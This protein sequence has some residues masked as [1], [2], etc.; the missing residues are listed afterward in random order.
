MCLF[1]IRAQRQETGR[2]LLDKEG[3]LVL[4]CGQCYECKSKRA[5]EWS[6]RATHE[7]SQYFDNC[8][9]T[10]TYDD[11]HLSSQFIVKS[12]FQKFMKRLRKKTQANIRYMVS[13]EYGS[14]TGRPHHHAIIFGWSPPAQRFI[15]TTAKGSKLYESDYI[16]DLWKFGFHSIGE[17]NEQTAYYIASYS[18]KST[19]HNIINNDTGEYCEVRDS[20]NVSTRPAIG[21]EFFLS[22][23]ENIVKTSKILPRYYKKLLETYNP[24]LLEWYENNSSLEFKTRSSHELLAKFKITEQK[25][26]SSDDGLRTAPEEKLKNDILTKQLIRDRDYYVHAT[27]K[28]GKQC[29]F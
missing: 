9:I 20:M 6:I 22:N 13:H 15:S 8:F 19:K 10:L 14:K 28:G 5:V 11:T 3:D 4:P 27:Q 16:N 26:L 12:N 25:E 23:M 2:P 18:L 17:A 1:P 29:K 7:M 24:D 21:K